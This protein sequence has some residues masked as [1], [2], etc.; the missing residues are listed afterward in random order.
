MILQATYEKTP[1]FIKTKYDT[2]GEPLQF[3]QV[4]RTAEEFDVP[5]LFAYA[6]LLIEKT[7]LAPHSELDDSIFN[8][9]YCYPL[10]EHP[11]SSNDEFDIQKMKADLLRDQIDYNIDEI[12]NKELLEKDEIVHLIKEVYPE[13]YSIQECLLDN[14][15]EYDFQVVCPVFFDYVL[16]DDDYRRSVRQVAYLERD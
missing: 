14:Y 2:V 3:E 15:L 9:L 4:K 12:A 6:G 16:V 1:L 7:Y 11:F 5:D 8:R 10:W 13:V